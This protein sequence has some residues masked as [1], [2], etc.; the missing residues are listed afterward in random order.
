M[1]INIVSAASVLLIVF[2]S[3]GGVIWAAQ[4]FHWD[5]RIIVAG[6]TAFIASQVVHLPLN[7]GLGQMGWLG[8]TLP[9][10]NL[11]ALIL[12]LTAGLCEELARY[13]AMRWW[14]SEV[15]DVSKASGFGL[16]HGGI[17]ALLIGILG[18][19]SIINMIALQTMD[20]STLGLEPAQLEMVEQQVLSFQ[21]QPFWQPMLSFVERSM[22]VINHVWMSVLVM[23]SLA[24][25][26]V[27][28]L[29]AAILW[30]TLINASAV[31][32]LR[33][34][35][36]LATEAALFACTLLAIFGWRSL[37]DTAAQG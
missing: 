15:R 25:N 3:I 21:E 24:R 16:G 26:Q 31:M 7:W 32:V 14:V 29:V 5:K 28:W 35:G 19:F 17:E 10:S 22:A 9:L 1:L 37:R 6:A 12:G 4:K 13:G 33:D 23:V 18:C 8:A 2:G 36:A 27:R 11:D 20:L 30:H 34:H